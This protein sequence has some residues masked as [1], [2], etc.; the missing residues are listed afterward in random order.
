MKHPHKTSSQGYAILF[1]VLLV[2]IILAI[3]MGIA[4]IALKEL[5]FTTTGRNSHIGFFAADTA[6]EC[7][8]YG[9]RHGN[10]LSDPSH[11]LTCDNQAIH[12]YNVGTI[13]TVTTY[14]FNNINVEDGCGYV[15][16]LVDTALQETTINSYGYNL[17]CASNPQANNQ[18]VERL[19]TYTLSSGT[20]TATGGSATGGSASGTTAMQG[21][22]GIPNGN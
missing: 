13:G 2:S 14:H 7:A 10:V 4:N 20:G 16:V 1:T 6:G 8:L 18:S 22:T 3:T 12:A 17:T 5:G 21:V 9:I 11:I 15:T 19:L